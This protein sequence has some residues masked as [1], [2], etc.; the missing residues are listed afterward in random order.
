MTNFSASTKIKEQFEAAIRTFDTP[1]LKQLLSEGHLWPL[2]ALALPP[3]TAVVDNAL[4]RLNDRT[5]LRRTFSD[6]QIVAGLRE[7]MA[8]LIDHE[9]DASLQEKD[10]RHDRLQGGCVHRLL[11]FGSVREN[12]AVESI[13]Q[14]VLEM[15]PE[16]A[17]TLKNYQGY[18]AHGLYE[19]ML[20]TPGGGAPFHNAAAFGRAWN[21]RHALSREH[22]A[23]ELGA[24]LG[25]PR[26]RHRP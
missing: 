10:S 23:D 18:T 14:A 16:S 8:L 6:D 22:R 1:T 20:Q 26:S 21:A 4:N 13:A 7:Q 17:L 24:G 5:G 19:A 9:Y 25:T 11:A 2:H 12:D 3:W 15:V